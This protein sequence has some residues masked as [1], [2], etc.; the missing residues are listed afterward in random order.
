MS[1]IDYGNTYHLSKLSFFSL[2]PEDWNY[3]KLKIED[4]DPY[5]NKPFNYNSSYIF[6]N[7]IKYCNEIFIKELIKYINL[8][9]D[10]KIHV[11]KIALQGSKTKYYYSLKLLK[12]LFICVLDIF[13]NVFNKTLTRKDYN[14]SIRKNTF[15][16]D[17]K[18]NLRDFECNEEN[19]YQKKRNFII[20]E[21]RNKYYNIINHF[22]TTEEIKNRFKIIC[23]YIIDDIA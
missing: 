2:N 3:N 6:Y 19:I 18:Y 10:L 11:N 8:D 20:T 1:V 12:H 17:S 5:L 23:D 15:F 16:T 9:E 4:I 7:C 13:N 21:T 14:K 22:V